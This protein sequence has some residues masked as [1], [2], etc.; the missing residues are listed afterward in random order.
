VRRQLVRRMPGSAPVQSD[1]PPEEA[2]GVA[3]YYAEV[4]SKNARK[5]QGL[6]DRRNGIKGGK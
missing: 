6:A 3:K 1:K 2:E 4:G 5:P